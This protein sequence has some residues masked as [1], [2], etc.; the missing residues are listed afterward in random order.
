MPARDQHD[1]LKY[2]AKGLA[3][4]QEGKGGGLGEFG[5]DKGNWRG[6]SSRG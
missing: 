1:N 3:W 4:G 2:T 6:M 5:K